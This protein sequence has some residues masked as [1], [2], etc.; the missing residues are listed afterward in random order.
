MATINKFQGLREKFTLDKV[1]NFLELCIL[2]YV[3]YAFFPSGGNIFIWFFKF[4]AYLL[5]VYVI[6]YWV[7][8]VLDKMKWYFKANHEDWL[9]RQ[10][11]VR[12]SMKEN[13]IRNDLV[14]TSLLYTINLYIKRFSLLY[15]IKYYLKYEKL[16]SFIAFCFIAIVGY[17]AFKIFFT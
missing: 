8:I 17:V 11:D 16:A 12:Y 15:L 4:L 13:S 9:R 3:G 10:Y 5:I 6:M 1:F 7:G 2:L 14:G